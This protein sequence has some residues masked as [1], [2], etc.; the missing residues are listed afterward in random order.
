MAYWIVWNEPA[1][2]HLL[3]DPTGDVGRHMFSRGLRITTAAKAKVGKRTGALEASINMSQE[4]TRT[5]QKMTIGSPLSYAYV[6]HEGARPH[7]IRA[8]SGGLL[9][10]SARGRVVYTREVAHPGIRPNRYL[11]TF[12]YMVK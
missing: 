4:P 9:R 6:H 12:L 8:D 3:K 10:F 5:G 1:L 11:S 2:F 7:I